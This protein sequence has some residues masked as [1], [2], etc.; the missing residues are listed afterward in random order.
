VDL[1]ATLIGQQGGV[2]GATVTSEVT[3]PDGNT[4]TLTLREFQAGQ[5]RASLPANQS[6]QYSALL[7]ATKD[8]VTRQESI[9]WT[10]VDPESLLDAS[11]G[12]NET[13]VTQ[14]DS[15]SFDLDLERPAGT[16]STTT[17]QSSVDTYT[18]A[19]EAAELAASSRKQIE[20]ASISESMKTAALA[21]KNDSVTT[22]AVTQSS[23]GS[24][25]VYV[26]PSELT[27]PDGATMSA[28]S[29]TTN[30]TTLGLTAG[31]NSTINVTVNTPSGATPGN[32]TGN[33]TLIAQGAVV[34]ADYQLTV[35]EATASTYSAR[36]VSWS[37]RWQTVSDTG[38]AYYRGKISDALSQLYFDDVTVETAST[39]QRTTSETITR[40]ATS[41]GTTASNPS[42]ADSLTFEYAGEPSDGTVEVGERF[43]HEFD[44][45][46][47]AS[48][49]PLLLTV[50]APIDD[51]LSY[52]SHAGTLDGDPIALS[53]T[54][55]TV[56]ID[57]Q[58]LTRLT[59][60]N[61][62]LPKSGM[63]TLSVDIGLIAERTG[64]YDLYTG[65]VHGPTAKTLPLSSTDLTVEEATDDSNEGSD[66]SDGGPIGSITP[67]PDVCTG[68]ADVDD[69]S[70]DAAVVE[71]SRITNRTTRAVI[72]DA[73][74]K[75]VTI[76]LLGA[77]RSN[78][79]VGLTAVDLVTKN[80]SEYRVFVTSQEAVPANLSAIPDSQHADTLAYA[81]LNS[82]VPANDVEEV[83]LQLA[84]AK[85][86][87]T[88]QEQLVLFRY[89][90]DSWTQVDVTAEG[91]SNSSFNYTAE[92]DALGT[93]A[94]ARAQPS[95]AVTEASLN[96]TTIDAGETVEV[97]ATVENSGLAA[98][99]MTVPVTVAGDRVDERIVTVDAGSSTTVTFDLSPEA[100]EELSVTI[101]EATAGELTVA[102]TETSTESTDSSDNIPG[103]GP[104]AAV[105]SVLLTIGTLRRR[106]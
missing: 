30:R 50:Y 16:T 59:L 21:I 106:A 29:V 58:Q 86:A 93:F 100:A 77:N 71:T 35:T 45:R 32:Y 63:Q 55:E 88:S 42:S 33:L 87:V 12:T 52:T 37:D 20:N 24:M 67:I 53:S 91:V 22:T 25:S 66:D 83:S 26:Q 5:Y 31:Q 13:N 85:Q 9:S 10:V 95:L 81:T 62:T 19:D 27:G 70:D 79:S 6:G 65:G 61:R 7:T 90:D 46:T 102:A 69:S 57:G 89:E 18:F 3:L 8:N 73:L 104:L 28:A 80:N 43:T 39:D 49:G 96:T 72:S 75:R 14:G 4:T 98:G 78:V 64:S 34:T 17:A 1:T 48:D 23:S 92:T 47:N 99:E 94:V 15:V 103:F 82:T 68:C 101:N 60:T 97:S 38:K 40:Q 84:A 51:G 76:P 2:S 44:V 11:T 105:L 74:G 36:I 41:A 56:R 54:T